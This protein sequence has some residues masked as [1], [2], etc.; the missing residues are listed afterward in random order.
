LPIHHYYSILFNGAIKLVFPVDS[1]F[2]SHADS[3]GV[4]VVCH[5]ESEE[6]IVAYVLTLSWN[7]QI[8]VE[9]PSSLEDD[10]GSADVLSLLA[11]NIVVYPRD[12]RC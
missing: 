10:L 12:R 6:K 3:E 4:T 7:M 5:K 9:A 11:E 8:S 1:S 2:K